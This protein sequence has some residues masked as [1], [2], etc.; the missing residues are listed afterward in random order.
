MK[1]VASLVAT[2]VVSGWVG[3]AP[4]QTSFPV[5][6]RA[7]DN[8][9]G[10]AFARSG[11]LYVAE[12]GRGGS[13]PCVMLRGENACYGATGAVT[14]FFRGRQRRIATRLPSYAGPSGFA[15]TGPHDVGVDARGRVF[16]LI[17]LGADPAQRAAFGPGGASFGTL[18]RLGAGGGR[19]RVA[20][21]AAFEASANPA[22]PP[23]DSNPFGLLRDGR[24]WIVAEAGGNSL[25]RVARGGAISVLSV[26]PSRPAR[27][28]DSVPTSVVRGP[29]G[30]YY[31]GELTGA[32]FVQGAARVYRVV[33]G[34]PP[35][36]FLDNLTA[37]IDLAI[38]RSGRLYVLQHATGTGLTGS[39]A[40]IRVAPDGTRTTLATEGLVNPTSVAIGFDGDVYVSNR[41]LSPD[42]GQVVRIAAGD[43]LDETFCVVPRVTGKTVRAARIA[44]ARANCATGTI[45]RVRSS[46]V[47][48]RRVIASRPRAGTRLAYRSRV[49]LTV[50][51]GRRPGVSPTL[52]GR[53]VP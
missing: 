1:V 22:G 44:L 2:I 5:V 48:K 51:L 43:N 50:G 9:R 19:V 13:G 6:M 26:F 35:Q 20:D 3:D 36:I 24:R 12:A 46:A 53:A 27:P 37:V 42:A 17:G 38:G 40:L 10:L 41:G 34:E 30:T 47:A 25:L 16:V 52:T 45:R 18:V 14:R 7:L 21:V 8:P 11:A 39:G 31:V 4:A 33:A 29:N 15:A 23:F 28:T 49:A 32:P